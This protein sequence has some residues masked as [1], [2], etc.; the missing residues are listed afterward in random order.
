MGSATDDHLKHHKAVSITTTEE[1]KSLERGRGVSHTKEEG[2][3][4]TSWRAEKETERD[5]CG[6]LL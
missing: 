1:G 6:V 5:D 4:G 3:K 2:S